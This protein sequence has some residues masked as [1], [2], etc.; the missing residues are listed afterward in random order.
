MSKSKKGS[1]FERE[2]PVILSK[3][4]TD[5]KR[6][7]IFWRVGGSGGR[8]KR[9]GRIG[10]NTK[11]QH[12]DICAS[13]PLGEPLIDLI[14]MELKRGYSKFSIADLVD[15]PGKALQQY[16]KWFAQ[17]QESHEQAGSFTWMIITRRDHRHGLV[18]FPKL[19][20]DQLALVSKIGLAY[21][22]TGVIT[23]EC[24]SFC[25]VGMKLQTFLDFVTPDNIKK[26]SQRV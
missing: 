26:L 21:E 9:R 17:V 20:W 19:L 22:T 1:R 23:F 13:D 5:G 11:G 15:K 10:S 16:E 24:K 4:W 2:I 7:D 6:S 18:F 3:W 25:V 8:A 12:G 14:T